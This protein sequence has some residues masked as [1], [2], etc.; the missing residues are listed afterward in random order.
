MA[1]KRNV[2]DDQF[3][4]M[5]GFERAEAVRQAGIKRGSRKA[6]KIA[7]RTFYADSAESRKSEAKGVRS[8][9]SKYVSKFN[10]PNAIMREGKKEIES[11]NRRALTSR[12]E[13]G[14][15]VLVAGGEARMKD[16]RALLTQVVKEANDK[17][18]KNAARKALRLAKR[19]K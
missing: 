10:D 19:I 11:F 3:R 12:M 8:K 1:K 17:N 14:K 2:P 13:K 18:A 16:L 5:S 15:P 9:G 4:K 6:G 7:G